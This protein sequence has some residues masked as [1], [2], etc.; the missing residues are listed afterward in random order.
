[1]KIPQ[2]VVGY[3]A[4]FL[5][6]SVQ[7]IDSVL[8]QASHSNNSN[9]IILAQSQRSVES[10]RKA[11]NVPSAT[12][13]LGL[14]RTVLLRAN[15]ANLSRNY[16]ILDQLSGPQARKINNVAVLVESFSAIREQKIDISFVATLT[17]RF[18]KMPVITPQGLLR[19]SG[20]FDGSHSLSFDIFF[21]SNDGIWMLYAIAVRAVTK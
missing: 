19:V 12:E 20:D 18:S 8:A 5:F 10:A 6:L 7:H 17:P 13:T 1:M 4:L 3:S 21:E 11:H 15:D 9:S 14:V 2:A 16:T